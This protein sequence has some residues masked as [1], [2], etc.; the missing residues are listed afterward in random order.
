MEFDVVIAGGGFA[1]AYCGRALGRA[2]A[3]PEGTQ[4][5]ALIA[6]QN[7]L[8]FQPMIPEVAG[9]SLAPLDVVNPLRQFC[10]NVNVLQGT[11]QKI[12]WAE[13]TILM[14]GGRF[15]RDHTVGFR[16]LVMALGSVTNLASVPG[17]SEYGWPMRNVADAIRLRAAIINRLE[18][19]N[20][21]RDEAAIKRVF[22][23]EFGAMIR[24]L[25][26]CTRAMLREGGAIILGTG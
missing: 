16:H 12:N 26:E 9:S 1:G 17:M 24:D 15:T 22:T 18:E 3:K 21:Q 11:I 14:D 4:R 25:V 5:V 10:R 6:E 7:V 19:A 13:K 8:V 23:P 2:F 20:L